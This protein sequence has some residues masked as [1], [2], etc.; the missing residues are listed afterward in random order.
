ME[1]SE[2]ITIPAGKY[3]EIDGKGNTISRADDSTNIVSS[4]AAG[5][6]A[7]LRVEGTASIKNLTIDAKGDDT[8]RLRGVVVLG[9]ANLTN[10]AI[11]GAYVPNDWGGALVAGGGT[12]NLDNCTITRNTAKIVDIHHIRRCGH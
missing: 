11:T 4:G 5:K 7:M 6:N 10:C 8:H 2:R 1:I 9:T 3:V 12:I